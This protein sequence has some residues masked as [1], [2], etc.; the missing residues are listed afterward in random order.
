MIIPPHLRRTPLPTPSSCRHCGSIRG[1]SLNGNVYCR[2]C[3]T[4]RQKRYIQNNPRNNY[5]KKRYLREKEKLLH[6]QKIYR[7]TNKTKIAIKEKIRRDNQA[8]EYKIWKGMIARCTVKSNGSYSRYGGRGIVVCDRWLSSYKNF[9]EDM[10]PRLNSEYSI[11]RKDVNGNYEPG[12]CFWA[13]AKQQAN[14]RTNTVSNRI[15]IS[16]N[17]PIIYKEKIVTIKEFS[18][19]EDIPLIVVK[20]RYTQHAISEWIIYSDCDNR[21]Y[22]Y[23][24][25]F[26]NVMELTLMHEE[27]FSKSSYIKTHQ[28]LKRYGWS[29]K[30]VMETP[31]R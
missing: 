31:F 9:F 27:P 21:Y 28:R 30:K 13:T 26:Y 24:N 15:K 22:E 3:N 4:K 2:T 29:V 12:N 19:L 8:P 1:R 25:K 18:I 16:D 5:Y 7:Q 10:G 23:N 11:E 20:Y 17:S 6:K 14:N